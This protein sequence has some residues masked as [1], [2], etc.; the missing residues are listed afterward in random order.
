MVFSMMISG[1]VIMKLWELFIVPSFHV[2][3]ITLAQSIGLMLIKTYI[4]V[5]A[6]SSGDKLTPEK[7]FKGVLDAIVFAAFTLGIAWV[8]TLFF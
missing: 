8:I 7:I 2:S 3:Q 6:P 4:T 1:C 5:K